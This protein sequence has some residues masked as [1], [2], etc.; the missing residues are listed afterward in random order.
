MYIINLVLYVGL[1][2]LLYL[3]LLIGTL[4]SLILLTPVFLFAFIISIMERNL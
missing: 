1:M 2:A 4:F 3:M